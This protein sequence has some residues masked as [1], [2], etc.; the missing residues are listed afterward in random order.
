MLLAIPAISLWAAYV[1]NPRAVILL[2]AII[3]SVLVL[4]SL[5]SSIFVLAMQVR[6]SE[7]ALCIRSIFGESCVAWQEVRGIRIVEKH[8]NYLPPMRTDR[9]VQ[10]SY[11]SLLAPGMITLNPNAWPEPEE[12]EFFR[13]LKD[14]A[15]KQGFLVSIVTTN[16]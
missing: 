15:A 11:G 12:G 7:E 10:I 2:A 6:V 4:R 14:I 16:I 1:H 9:M 13:V 8:R 5:L 3:F